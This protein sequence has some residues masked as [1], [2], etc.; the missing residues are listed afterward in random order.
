MRATLNGV[1]VAESDDTVIVEG[2]HYFPLDSVNT[3]L[4]SDSS[5]RTVCPWKGLAR[6]NDVT[7]NGATASDAAW[8][9]PATFAVRPARQGAG[10]VL[11]GCGGGTVPTFRC[12]HNSRGVRVAEHARTPSTPATAQF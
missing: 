2:N 7:V 3:S 4:L 12:V 1:V 9:Y 5:T 6:Y 10:G 8:F 11:E